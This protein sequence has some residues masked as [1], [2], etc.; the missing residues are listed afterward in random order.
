M[1]IVEAINT[2]ISNPQKISN[3]IKV[4]NEYFFLYND[5]YKW[6]LNK[7]ENDDYFLFLYPDKSKS[8]EYFSEFTDWQGYSDFVTY[9]SSE[10]KTREAIE[11]FSELY[12]LLSKKTLGVDDILDDIISD[13]NPF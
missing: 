7:N 9:K 10:I 2:M 8:L 12:L 3:I 4:N 13:D 11:S 6:S 1:K 5:K